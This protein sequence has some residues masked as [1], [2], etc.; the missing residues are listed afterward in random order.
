MTVY[1]TEAL[2]ITIR[3]RFIHKLKQAFDSSALKVSPEL[4]DSIYDFVIGSDLSV[5]SSV[6]SQY[7]NYVPGISL[8]FTVRGVRCLLPVNFSSSRPWISL[9]NYRTLS[10]SPINGRLTISSAVFNRYR[11]HDIGAWDHAIMDG[12]T[13]VAESIHAR[14]T[15]I[16]NAQ[17]NLAILLKQNRTLRQLLKAFPPI[18]PFVSPHIIEKL[19]D[20]PAARVGKYEGVDREFLTGMAAMARMME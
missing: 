16:I 3:D 9:G 14:E 7:L 1:V 12:L 11:I 10:T 2:K 6:P 4:A 18:K 19:A 8:E 20:E 15:N 13:A 5:L 17:D